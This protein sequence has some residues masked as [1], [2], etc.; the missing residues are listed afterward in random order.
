MMNSHMKNDDQSHYKR[1][2][3]GRDPRLRGKV[4]LHVKQTM[5][6]YKHSSYT[7]KIIIIIMYISLLICMGLCLIIMKML[8]SDCLMHTKGIN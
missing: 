7:K 4:L 1:V 3:S 5:I 8:T 6:I 2:P